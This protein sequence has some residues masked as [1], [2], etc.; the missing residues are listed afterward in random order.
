MKKIYLL[1]LLPLC[2]A[3]A[4]C[5]NDP[6]DDLSGKYDDVARYTFTEARVSPSLK[7][8]KGV[9]AL[10]L[11]LMNKEGDTFTVA[12]GSTEW[13]LQPGSYSPVYSVD[14]IVNMTYMGMINID[15]PGSLG[16]VEG[17][18][19]VIAEKDAYRINGIFT[20]TD[21]GK[22][23]VVNF[24][25]PLEFEIGEDDPEPSGYTVTFT[26]QQATKTDPVTYQPIP[27]EGL[28]KY[29]FKITDPSGNDAGTV[30]ALNLTDIETSALAGDYTIAGSPEK[31]WLADNG[32]VV[33]DWG[34]AGGTYFTGSDGSKRYITGGVVNISFATGINGEQLIN[35]AGSSL[36]AINADGSDAGSSNVSIKFAQLLQNTGTELRDL[37]MQSSVLGKEIAYSVF[38]PEGYDPS[39]QYP[40]LYMLNGASGNNNDWL[41]QGMVASYA[42]SA[43]KD[44][45]IIFPNGCPDGFDSFYVN[46]YNNGGINYEEFFFTEFLPKV[47]ADFNIKPGKGNRGIAGLSMGGYGSLYYG[48]AHPDMFCYIYACSPATYVEG[49][50]NLYDMM[51][52]EGLPGI[53]VEIGT[54]D[55]LY[56]SA[57]GFREAL[58]YS[59]I[60]W[61]FIERDGAHDWAFWSVCTPKILK[62]FASIFE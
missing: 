35:I 16:C 2:L 15:E 44:M 11:E 26:K 4:G 18:L 58:G 14:N 49:T 13:I 33:P 51:W 55:F 54:S 17:N 31:A 53:T 12:I 56:E 34:M 28:S 24:R 36:P 40:V 22:R 61:D 45:V 5:S 8:Q 42:A 23:F 29:T 39:R 50:P 21:A 41:Q 9:K 62:K 43:G 30:E 48:L 59:A 6:I 60:D 3:L 37:K 47:E 46:G 32:W 20:D 52:T 19:T 38:L 25:G 10:R 27:L 1:L 57:K 7:L